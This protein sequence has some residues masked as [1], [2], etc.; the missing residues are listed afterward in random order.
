ML[1]HSESPSFSVIPVLDLRGGM[2][3]HAQRGQRQAYQPLRSLL[4]EGCA[5]L[6]IAA[7][8]LNLYPFTIFYIA[9]LDAIEKCGS[10]RALIETLATRH[11]QVQWWV[12]DGS[13]H[14]W[15]SKPLNILQVLG[16]ESHPV[17]QSFREPYVLS[18]DERAGELLGDTKIHHAPSLWPRRL[19]AM[20]LAEVGADFGPNISIISYY[21]TEHPTHDWYASGGVRDLSDL[22]QLRDLGAKGVLIATALH[23]KKVTHSDLMQLYKA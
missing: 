7:V 14:P 11:P 13:T 4:C 17:L 6:D 5:P 15:I 18:L 22:V 8:L 12:D 21:C 9:D 2:V 20:T 1:F 23:Q 19:I 10:H 3:V 16:T